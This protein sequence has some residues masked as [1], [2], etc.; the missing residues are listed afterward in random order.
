MATNSTHKTRDKTEQPAAVAIGIDLAKG[1]CDLVGLGERG[2]QL[3]SLRN[4][5][6]PE[7]MELLA[8]QANVHVLMEACG[9]AHELATAINR[10]GRGH[11]AQ[12]LKAESVKSL[13]GSGQKNDVIDAAFIARF[14][15]LGNMTARVPIKS[16]EL[17]QLQQ[18]DVV[19][20]GFLKNRTEWGNRIHALLLERGCPTNASS[21]M[22]IEHKLPAYVEK[23]KDKFTDTDRE[24]IE[25]MRKVWLFLREQELEHEKRYET[26]AVALLQVK[27]LMTVPDIGWNA[28]VM[29][30]LVI[31]ED[32]T[33][34]GNSLC[35]TTAVG[36]VPRQYST[37]GKSSLHHITKHGSGRARS[38]LYM[39]ATALLYHGVEKRPGNL[40]E[41]IRRISRS[42]KPKKVQAIALASKIT[43]IALQVLKTG[44]IYE[45]QP[46][47]ATAA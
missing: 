19:Q 46:V 17:Q 21:T 28:A 4:V 8:K 15:L 22:F 35:L 47:G 39:G 14:H 34:F 23:N 11:D 7:L 44:N 36:L 37:G 27:L 29:F 9:G 2:H 45:P 10:M 13:R 16:L 26:P 40:G 18:V 30:L 6:R 5:T 38:L 41:W 25:T 3:F 31:R 20:Q 32:A 33:R 12:L 24:E 42:G 43:R 1:H